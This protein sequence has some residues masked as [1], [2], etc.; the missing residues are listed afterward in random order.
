LGRYPD[1][2]EENLKHLEKANEIYLQLAKTISNW[3]VVD[4]MKDGQ[5]RTPE[6]IHQEVVSILSVDARRE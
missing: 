6:D 1:L 2:H 5:M 3:Y 4:C